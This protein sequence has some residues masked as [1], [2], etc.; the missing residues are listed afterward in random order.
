MAIT[1][2]TVDTSVKTIYT[3]VD[4]TDVFVVPSGINDF[5]TIVQSAIVLSNLEIT[6]DDTYQFFVGGEKLIL[7]DGDEIQIQASDAGAINTCISH[8]EV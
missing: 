4:D 2:N 7:G 3:S 1:V 8:T 6:A 5:S